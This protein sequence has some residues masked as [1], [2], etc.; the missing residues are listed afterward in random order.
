MITYLLTYLLTYLK[1]V[2]VQCRENITEWSIYLL[3]VY[4]HS[5]VDFNMA[6]QCLLV[7]YNLDYYVAM[8]LHYALYILAIFVDKCQIIFIADF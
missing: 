4:K 3:L 6:W 8:P 1:L 7:M 2:A 5:H